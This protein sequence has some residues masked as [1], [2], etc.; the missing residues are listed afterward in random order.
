MIDASAVPTILPRGFVRE[1]AGHWAGSKCGAERFRSVANAI[2]PSGVA[3]QPIVI[4]W[5]DA[6]FNKCTV[7]LRAVRPDH[8]QGRFQCGNS[9]YRKRVRRL[10]ATIELAVS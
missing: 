9:Q 7:Q 8:V 3:S 10:A 1:T 2:T 4:L 6:A 5:P